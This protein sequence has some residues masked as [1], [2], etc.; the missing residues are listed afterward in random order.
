MDQA[1]AAV[2]DHAP[3]SAA[4]RVLPVT[5]SGIVAA[6]LSMPISII[7]VSTFCFEQSLFPINFIGCVDS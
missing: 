3:R 4:G 6:K 5:G 2:L 1:P 7:I